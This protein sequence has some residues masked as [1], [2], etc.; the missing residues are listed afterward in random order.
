VEGD[1]INVTSQNSIINVKSSL[2]GATQTL[3]AAPLGNSTKDE[4]KALLTQLES[5][6]KE[7]P[8]EKAEAA[9]ALADAARETISKVA[10]PQPNKRS[11]QAS[12]TQMM[13]LASDVADALPIAKDIA[14]AI[15]GIFGVSL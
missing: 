13:E 11:V 8:P 2:E 6:L 15:S 4:L 1:Q 10:K 3:S 7:A 9:E 12:V 14:K 5:R